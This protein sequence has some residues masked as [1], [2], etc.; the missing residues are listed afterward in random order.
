MDQFIFSD[1]DQES[2][3]VAEPAVPDR[4]PEH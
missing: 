1:I 4:D 2:L 3:N